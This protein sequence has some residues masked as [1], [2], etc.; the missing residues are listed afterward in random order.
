MVFC[1]RMIM[2][3]LALCLV[4][5]PAMAGPLEDGQA[6]FERKD[7]ATAMKFWRPLADG[8]DVLAQLGLGAMY[9]KGEGVDQD[10]T[11]A[12]KWLLLSAD[13]GNEFAQ[14]SLG[15]LYEGGRG[16]PQDFAQAHMWYNL[17]AAS[18][19]W[20]S[21]GYAIDRDNIAMKMTPDQIGEAQRLAREWIAA[22]PKP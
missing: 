16:V 4:L 15:K 21:S 8:G 18:S 6:A 22:H 7:Y 3:G 5:Q 13:Q 17:A 9:L 20:F 2:C 11:E 10:N 19:S 12:A 14:V 1:L